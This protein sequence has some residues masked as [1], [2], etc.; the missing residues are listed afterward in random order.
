MNESNK[1]FYPCDQT[2]HNDEAHNETCESGSINYVA[3]AVSLVSAAL[4]TVALPILTL[5]LI[6][7]SVKKR[8]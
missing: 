6:A 3:A 5:A 8:K 2:S 7:R 1:I 4:I